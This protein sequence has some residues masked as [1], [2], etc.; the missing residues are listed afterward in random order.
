MKKGGV[1]GVWGG[2]LVDEEEKEELQGEE[3]LH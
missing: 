2:E 3:G 1:E